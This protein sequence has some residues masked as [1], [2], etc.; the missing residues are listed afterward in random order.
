MKNLKIE[1]L[2][3]SDY[4]D[5]VYPL[6]LVIGTSTYIIDSPTTFKENIEFFI[7]KWGKEGVLKRSVTGRYGI[8]ENHLYDDYLLSLE[9]HLYKNNE[10]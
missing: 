8:E 10:G 6:H 4:T 9:K 1:D 3:K 2:V 7:K 5:Y